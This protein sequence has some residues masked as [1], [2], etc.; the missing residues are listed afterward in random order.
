MTNSSCLAPLPV[1]THLPGRQRLHLV[2]PVI[3]SL[4]SIICV[5]DHFTFMA[6]KH[7]CSHVIVSPYGKVCEYLVTLVAAKLIGTLFKTLPLVLLKNSFIAA[8]IV[9]LRAHCLSTLVDNV[10]IKIMTDYK[11]ILACIRFVRTTRFPVFITM[12]IF[13]GFLLFIN[14]QLFLSPHQGWGGL[15]DGLHLSGQ[16]RGDPQAVRLLRPE[17]PSE[18]WKDGH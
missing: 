3:L 1:I 11:R 13:T 18:P 9:T 7:S 8:Y 14:R 17:A 15:G 16:D 10:L 5:Q 2:L 6:V 12:F 4:Y